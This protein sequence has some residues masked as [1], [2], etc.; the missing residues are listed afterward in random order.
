MA[1]SILGLCCLTGV[2]AW[3]IPP[4]IP[5]TFGLEGVLLA[6]LSRVFLRTAKAQLGFLTVGALGLSYLAG[7]P[8]FILESLGVL[9]VVQRAFVV[10][11][12]VIL[13]LI[14]F[15][16][17]HL[18]IFVIL[19]VLARAKGVIKKAAL[20][21]IFVTF[22]GFVVYFLLQKG[23]DGVLALE[24]SLTGGAV[25]SVISSNL[26]LVSS[27]LTF[28]FA[29]PKNFSDLTL[30]LLFSKTGIFF[31][32]VRPRRLQINGIT[33]GWLLISVG[34][35]IHSARN[36]PRSWVSGDKAYFIEQVKVLEKVNWEEY[37]KDKLSVWLRGE[38][39]CL[40][41]KALAVPADLGGY[42]TAAL[43]GVKNAKK[44]S[45]E[46]KVFY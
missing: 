30:A 18:A 38:R 20:L 19:T 10:R 14:G 32:F 39:V 12:G 24:Q 27:L 33:V 21:T 17:F 1:V 44:V 31:Y 25:F 45:N 3:L 5:V 43:R 15:Q 11:A 4:F 42:E 8:K 16:Q 2:L 23:A 7:D 34:I 26:G 28:Y 35:L 6:L 46:S 37:C 9:A 22:G 36:L 41:G 40:N 13:G 29:R